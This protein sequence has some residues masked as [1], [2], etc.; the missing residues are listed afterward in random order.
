MNLAIKYF[1][2]G[3]VGVQLEHLNVFLPLD[4]CASQARTGNFGLV[5]GGNHPITAARRRLFAATP[6]P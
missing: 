6:S 1:T 3:L 4:L 5:I 2:G